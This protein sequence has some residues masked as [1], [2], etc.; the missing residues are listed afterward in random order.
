MV[1][2]IR[3]IKIILVIFCTRWG[4]GGI[5]RVFGLLMGYIRVISVII[6]VTRVI[7]D[8]RVIRGII[9]NLIY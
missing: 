6:R 9:L 5:I 4:Y 8:I 3:I 2:G 1:L 7:S